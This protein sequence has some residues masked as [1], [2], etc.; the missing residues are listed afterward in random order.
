MATMTSAG[1]PGTTAAAG[2]Q[3]GDER[4][5]APPPRVPTPRTRLSRG[6]VLMVVAGLVAVLGN[7][8]L[9]TGGETSRPAVLAARDL[10]PGTVVRSGDLSVA[11]VPDD[12]SLAGLAEDPD[13]LVGL[14]VTDRVETGDLLRRND[15]VEPTAVDREVRH[16]SVPIPPERAV[17][18]D[19]RP[20]DRVDVIGASEEGARYL[21]TDVRVVAVGQ[22]SAGLGQ[23]T[24]HHVVLEVDPAG[25]LCLADALDGDRLDVVRSTGQAPVEAEGCA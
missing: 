10:V 25:A 2:A 12:D 22:P 23:L 13:A 1:M 14:V 17:G 5:A 21:V 19:L 15:A 4:Q 8:V 20:D 18:G 11:T 16:L 6:H 7:L 9:L 24:Q 3:R